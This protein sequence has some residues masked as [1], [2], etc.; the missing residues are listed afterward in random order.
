[1]TRYKARK[2]AKELADRLNRPWIEKRRKGPWRA[3]CWQNMG[4]NYTAV[5]GAMTVYPMQNHRGGD[6]RYYTLL[7]EYGAG[8]MLWTS[9]EGGFK[10]PQKAVDRQ[11]KRANRA[12]AHHRD[13]IDSVEVRP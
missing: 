8:E 10:D 6:T 5:N 9:N 1:M 13:I 2:V 3:K 4:W 11:L 12:M 7:G